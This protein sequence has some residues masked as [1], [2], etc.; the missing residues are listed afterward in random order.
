[1]AV[2]FCVEF[3]PPHVGGYHARGL[4]QSPCRGPVGKA[5]R[6]F[7]ICRTRHK[8]A[9]ARRGKEG[10]FWRALQQQIRR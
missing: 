7:Y 6:S 2:A 1:V 5:G 3:P 9:C 10:I 4:C 8:V